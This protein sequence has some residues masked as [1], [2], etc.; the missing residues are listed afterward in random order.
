MIKYKFVMKKN[1]FY[2]KLMN[3]QNFIIICIISMP[4]MLFSLPMLQSPLI[5]TPKSG[6][7]IQGVVSIKGSL[8]VS[9]YKSYEVSFAYDND[10][11]ETWFLIESSEES[12]NNR[13]LAMWDT[14]E[15]TDGDYKLRV[16]VTTTSNTTR[17]TIIENLHVRNYT[18][19]DAGIVQDKQNES[20][21]KNETA[22]PNMTTST[23]VTEEHQKNNLIFS[24][25]SMVRLITYT[26]LV[27]LV[28]FVAGLI[29]FKMR[30]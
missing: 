23:P 29:Y 12:V 28:L 26:G 3:I 10:D 16:K 9:T 19:Y 24:S 7:V 8:N 5:E 4:Q 15:I 17:I 2:K 6:A 13:L 22:K 30:K 25:S 14:S 21:V 1:E 18:T 11:S 20:D 27:V